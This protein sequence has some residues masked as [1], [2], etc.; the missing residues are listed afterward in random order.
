MNER[1]LTAPPVGK[2]LWDTK[3]RG[4]GAWRRVVGGDVNFVFKFR[5]PTARE[6]TGRGVQRLMTIGRWGRGD[7]G[8]DT[9]R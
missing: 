3:V 9:A 2:T 8:I 4:L 7:Y 6:A 5:S 1:T